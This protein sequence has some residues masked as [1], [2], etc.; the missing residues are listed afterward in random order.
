MT[1]SKQFTKGA[2][3][4]SQQSAEYAS[5]INSNIA[6]QQAVVIAFRRCIKEKG[7]SLRGAIRSIRSK[8]LTLTVECV[9]RLQSGEYKYISTS[10]LNILAQEVG[11]SNFVELL[12]KTG[13]YKDLL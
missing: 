5:V 10:V 7:V 6:I 3:K 11:Y 2:Y 8:N 9:C 4:T 1:F 12:F 13:A